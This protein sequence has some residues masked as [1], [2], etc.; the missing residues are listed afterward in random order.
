MMGWDQWKQGFDAWE[1]ATAQLV[2]QFMRSPQ[3]L[4]PAGQA[5]GAAMKLKAQQQQA[6]ADAWANMGLPTRK[7]QERSLHALN[8]I[9][10][11]LSD[12][13]EQLQETRAELQ[14]I[15]VQTATQAQAVAQA[16]TATEETAP[17]KPQAAAKKDGPAK[18]VDPAN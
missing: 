16:T 12:L 3:V 17:A 11:R 8:Q 4:G 10:S 5:M 2:E 1:N 14:A 13:E 15:K 9:Q 7:D 18:K 6:V